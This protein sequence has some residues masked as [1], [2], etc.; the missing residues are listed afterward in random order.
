MTLS[1]SG[2]HKV[3]VRHGPGCLAQRVAALAQ[4]TAAAT[5][6]VTES[7]KDGCFGFCH[8][9]PDEG[10]VALNT[11]TSAAQASTISEP[12]PH[13]DWATSIIETLVNHRHAN[14]LPTITTTRWLRGRG[15]AGV[16]LPGSLSLSAVV[17]WSHQVIERVNHRVDLVVVLARIEPREL[18]HE[19][20]P[21]RRRP[22]RSAIRPAEQGDVAVLL[23]RRE[24]LR[25]SVLLPEGGIDATR[26]GREFA[27]DLAHPPDRTTPAPAPPPASTRPDRGV[28]GPA[29]R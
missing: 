5:G 29:R 16:T 18:G 11:S 8:L 27:D 12:K 24:P 4:I 9:P 21:P 23:L 15:S 26:I 2:V 14:L 7:A 1:A 17:S 19:R 22:P 25:P 20:V 28:C 6:V 10:L 3:P 13:S